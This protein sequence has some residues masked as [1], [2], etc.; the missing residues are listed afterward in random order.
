MDTMIGRAGDRMQT[1]TGL[2]LITMLTAGCGFG[3]AASEGSSP[4]PADQPSAA[5]AARAEAAAATKVLVVIEENHTYDQM[6]DGM[7]FLADLSDTYGY[8]THWTAITHPSEP[9]YLAIA[10]G[11]TFGIR[12]DRAPEGHKSDIGSAPSVFDQ[13]LAAGKTAGTYAESMPQNCH[14][15]GGPGEAVGEPKYAVRHNPWVYFSA[16]RE[17]CLAY[18]VGLEQFVG[19]AERNALPN[20]GFLIPNLDNDAHD[21]SLATADAWLETQLTPVLQSEDFTSG[22][23]VVIVTADE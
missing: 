20:V 14:P 7:P 6:R 4:T 1:V 9:N 16:G 11:S 17:H 22:R 2:A 5:T 19:D 23:L 12:D 18:D 8:A 15:Y 21:G 13:A 3:N 10:G